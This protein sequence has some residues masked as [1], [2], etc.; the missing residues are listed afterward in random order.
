MGVVPKSGEASKQV[1][2]EATTDVLLK[3][4]LYGIQVSIAL[5]DSMPPM[6]EYIEQPVEAPQAAQAPQAPTAPET[7]PVAA[8]TPEASVVE[9]IETPQAEVKPA[10]QVKPRRRQPKA[11]PKTEPAVEPKT[12][13][14]AQPLTEE[15]AEA[16]EEAPGETEGE[17][18]DGGEVEAELT[19]TAV[20]AAAETVVQVAK[21]ESKE[22]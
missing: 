22:S 7:A 14:T 3:L 16:K 1:V 17:V 20:P 12:K 11:E 19:E 8:P 18:L 15:K 10:T 6:V 2:R 21:S 4:G 9:K 5:K 13:E